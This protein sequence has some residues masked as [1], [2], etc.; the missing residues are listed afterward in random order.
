M[1]FV[2]ASKIGNVKLSDG[3]AVKADGQLAGSPLKDGA[4]ILVNEAAA[5]H[6]G[7]DAFS[8]LEAIGHTEAGIV[9]DAGVVP[10]EPIS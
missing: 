5:I 3:K 1:P 2:V 4:D 7:M 9:S 8:H 6:W 10:L